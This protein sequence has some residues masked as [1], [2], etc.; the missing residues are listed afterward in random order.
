[1][2]SAV[3]VLKCFE[4]SFGTDDL[5]PFAGEGHHEGH[6]VQPAADQQ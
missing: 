3:K 6:H 2:A 5:F 4:F 1:M